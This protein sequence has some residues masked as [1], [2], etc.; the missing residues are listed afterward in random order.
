MNLRTSVA[1]RIGGGQYS[2]ALAEVAGAQR[3]AAMVRAEAQVAIAETHST[4]ETLGS[5]ISALGEASRLIERER[6]D[7]K[8]TNISADQK[9]GNDAIPREK[10]IPLARWAFSGGCPFT[11]A[12]VW[13]KTNFAFGTGIDG[14]T[15]PD[16]ETN[17][18]L[19]ILRAFWWEQSNQ[20]AMFST[21]RQYERSNQ[22]LCDGDLF[23]L[24]F[25]DAA[26]MVRVRRYDP[27][28]VASIVPDPEDP[29][30]PLYYACKYQRK[31]LNVHTGQMVQAPGAKQ[32]VRYYPDFQNTEQDADPLYSV[33]H[34]EG[35]DDTYRM[36]G[37]GQANVY[38][39]HVPL[40]RVRE[41]G[42]GVSEVA[43]SVRWFLASKRIVEDQ[44]TISAATARLMN[45]ISVAGTP[46]DLTALATTIKDSIGDASDELNEGGMSHAA[47]NL[48]PEG[49]EMKS[50][51]ASSR[52]TD[53]WQNDRMIRMRGAAGTGQALHYLADPENAS[54]ATTRTM[55]L[56]VLRSF[57]TYQALQIDTYRNLCGFE[58]LQNGIDPQE[59]E[60]DIPAPAMLQTEVGA[61]AGAL[62]D[63][64]DAGYMTQPL[65]SRALL[66]LFGSDDIHTDL[67]A[68]ADEAEARAAQAPAVAALQVEPE[69]E[70][71]E[72]E[73]AE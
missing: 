65:V 36:T 13:N 22:L 1:D 50:E 34:G 43:A 26:G 15:G 40:N 47:M 60:Y 20:S 2:D 44:A 6:E 46:G 69:P 57:E 19:Q 56:P 31:E 27:L 49:M 32:K 72:G 53:A 3:E 5:A 4:R 33:V 64:G 38:M 67:K 45:R 25:L 37:E 63:A 30:R 21:A 62:M 11:K 23:L 12:A 48:M 41:S 35:V 29:S 24:L 66:Q 68:I 54:L 9:G 51:R 8:W 52:A 70:E 61:T 28:S 39:M 73:D 42:F 18:A 71:E 59:A 10:A 17:T 58:L 55:E 7:A 16:A 14:P